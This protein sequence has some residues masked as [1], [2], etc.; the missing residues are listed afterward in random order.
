MNHMINAAAQVIS[1]GKPRLRQHPSIS[2]N[3]EARMFIR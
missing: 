3:T 2:L 1:L